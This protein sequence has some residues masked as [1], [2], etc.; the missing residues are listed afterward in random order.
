MM[1]EDLITLDLCLAVT[2]FESWLVYLLFDGG[3][4]YFPASLQAT[5]C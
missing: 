5:L 1:D 4:H 2:Y 3:L